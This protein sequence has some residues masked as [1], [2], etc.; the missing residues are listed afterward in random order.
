MQFRIVSLDLNRG[1]HPEYRILTLNDCL[2]GMVIPSIC[3]AGDMSRAG[4]CSTYTEYLLMVVI[5]A[6]TAA[7]I[8]K[9]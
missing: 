1:K 4:T 7:M 5:F 9:G 3:L 8:A 2:L 6:L